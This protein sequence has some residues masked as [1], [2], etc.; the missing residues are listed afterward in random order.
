ML[1]AIL[2]FGFVLALMI[3]AAIKTRR[4]EGLCKHEMVARD[5]SVRDLGSY[6]DQSGQ[7]SG[8]LRRVDY[9]SKEGDLRRAIFQLQWNAV[10]LL[11]DKPWHHYMKRPPK[12]LP[13]GKIESAHLKF[14]A[15]CTALPGAKGFAKAV[16]NL[17]T[18]PNE[19]F[20]MR[21]ENWNTGCVVGTE[22]F[23]GILQAVEAQAFGADESQ[24]DL[25]D[26]SLEGKPIQVRWRV[27]G[28]APKRILKLTAASEA[29]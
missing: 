5:G 10:A 6:I 8:S 12:F 14:A 20:I 29:H 4:L 19:P 24:P 23:A 18:H 28:A 3:L 16:K 26:L 7:N 27:E 22:T 21:E 2:F 11:E 17:Q 15:D 9:V 13:D 1:P 25:L